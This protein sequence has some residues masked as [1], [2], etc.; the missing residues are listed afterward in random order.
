M[1]RILLITIVGIL[2]F[3]YSSAQLADGSIAPDWTLTDVNGTAHNL[4]SYLDGSYTVFLDFSAVWCG[5][6]WGYH[7][8]GALED[9]YENHGPAGFPNVDANTT[10]DVMVF[11]IEGDASAL[12]CLQGTGCN[13][14]GD[15]I[16]G[17]NY[18][19][20]CTDGTVNND[21]TTSLYSIGYWPT[22]YMICPDRTLTEAGQDPNP[23]SLVTSP[24]TACSP[25]ATQPNDPSLFP[26]G[27]PGSTCIDSNNTTM[28]GTTLVYL[29]D[30]SPVISVQNQGMQALTSLDSI[31]VTATRIATGTTVYDSITSWSG[32]LQTYQVASIILPTITGLWGYEWIEIT[33][34]GPNGTM[35]PNSTNNYTNFTLSPGNII[36]ASINQNG[37][38]ITANGF[39]GTP[40]YSYVWSTG[41]TTQD[42]TPTVGGSY[43]VV[44]TDANGCVSDPIIY[45]FSTTSGVEEISIN[46]L[47]IY[48]N[49]SENVFNIAFTSEKVQ[50]FELRIMNVLGE[51]LY[52]EKLNDFIGVYSKQVSLSNYSKAIYFLEIE[53]DEGRVNKKLV[54]Q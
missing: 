25:A 53:T 11:M 34:S 27:G 14:Q 17:T 33:I 9:L 3:T 10:D 6:C 8:S 38:V 2:S 13:T 24:T 39:N 12:A 20:F 36:T 1:K 54:L 4:Y 5:P 29:G 43:S 30:I 15:W 45:I 40:P 32:N 47:N 44:V 52:T 23:Y 22:I 49:P 35:D 48:P 50:E 18:P 7:T 21:N 19:V 16:T 46:N 31:R 42:I 51:V 37:G 28:V 26:Y 41:L